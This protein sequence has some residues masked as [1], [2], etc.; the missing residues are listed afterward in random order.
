MARVRGLFGLI[1]AIDRIV[2]EIPQLLMTMYPNRICISV[3]YSLAV[4]STVFNMSTVPF[5]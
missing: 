4:S 1:R 5:P 3:A 2:V